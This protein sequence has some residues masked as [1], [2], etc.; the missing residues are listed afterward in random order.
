M[1]GGLRTFQLTTAATCDVERQWNDH[2][3]WTQLRRCNAWSA[4][5]PPTAL[6][7][8]PS[9]AES[10]GRGGGHGAYRATG[11]RAAHAWTR[12]VIEWRWSIVNRDQKCDAASHVTIREEVEVH[13][14]CWRWFATTACCCSLEL[15]EDDQRLW[16]LQTIV[17][18]VA[19]GTT[20]SLG[21]DSLGSDCPSYYI[22][23][24]SGIGHSTSNCLTAK[25]KNILLRFMHICI[26]S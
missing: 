18:S 14:R 2:N 16:T 4:A 21:C 1:F 15:D 12:D 5:G 3:E 9:W 6:D 11:N 25:Q 8:H 20:N 22:G 23:E 24:V 19:M 26:A 7:G 10:L 13:G 17:G